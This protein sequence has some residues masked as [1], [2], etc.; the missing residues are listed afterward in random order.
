MIELNNHSTPTLYLRLRR[1]V[2]LPKG[3]FIYLG[4]LAQLLVEPELEGKL[5]QII[6]YKPTEQD[7]NLVLINMLQIIKEVKTLEPD[8]K[9]E[10]F[11]EPH[12]LIELVK[13]K[14]AAN[15]FLLTFAC[16]LL[17]I[18]SGLAIMNFHADVSMMAV[19]QKMYTL[20]TG[21]V[22][23]HPLLLQIPYSFGIG[24]G[25]MIFFNRVFKKKFNEEPNPL[26]V[27]MFLYQESLDQ[28]VIAEEYR[29]GQKRSDLK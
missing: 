26:E 15:L 2:T 20:L 14:P 24:A 5:K 1:K 13:T 6:I 11:G 27:E 12:I 9:L 19:H 4:Q 7:G 23:E 22:L 28:Y 29:K 25:M 10:F 18:G 17:F 3:S 8:L 21:D 16:I